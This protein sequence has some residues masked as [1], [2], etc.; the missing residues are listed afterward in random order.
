[1]T[2]IPP[3]PPP[4]IMMRGLPRS[5]IRVR[6]VINLGI[7]EDVLATERAQFT[8]RG[9]GITLLTNKFFKP[10]LVSVKRV[11][12]TVQFQ[13][14]TIK[15][16]AQKTSLCPYRRR[17]DDGMQWRFRKTSDSNRFSQS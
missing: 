14:K 4:I 6:V 5:A 12:F 9:K 16:Y 3:K 8:A 13:L 7:Y 15:L 11:I 2:S 1:M 17:L 10:R